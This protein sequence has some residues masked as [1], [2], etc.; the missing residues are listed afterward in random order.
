MTTS[1]RSVQTSRPLTQL[2]VAYLCVS[3][4]LMLGLTGSGV[5]VAES[6]R[7]ALVVTPQIVIG[8]SLWILLRTGR[9]DSL[10]C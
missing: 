7:L 10:H 8:G 5:A 2:L 9:T 1:G 6:I 3:A 4:I